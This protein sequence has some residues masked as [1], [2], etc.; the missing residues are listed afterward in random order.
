MCFYEFLTA[1][2]RL[3]CRQPEHKV[4]RDPASD[5][6]CAAGVLPLSLAIATGSEHARFR[7]PLCDPERAQ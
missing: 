5:A 2:R 4:G 6:Q 7:S 3:A 1:R